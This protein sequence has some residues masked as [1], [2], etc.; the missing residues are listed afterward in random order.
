MSDVFKVHGDY[1]SKPSGSS[2]SGAPTISAP[3]DESVALAKAPLMQ[4]FSLES[5]SVQVVS[6]GALSQANVLVIKTVGGKVRAR[7]TSADGTT[8]SIPV[9]SFLLLI[10]ESVPITAVD[11]MRVSGVTTIAKVLLGQKST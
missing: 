2:A 10:S 3:I 9:D 8:Q 7:I 1:E 11:I 4:E 5:D 6:L